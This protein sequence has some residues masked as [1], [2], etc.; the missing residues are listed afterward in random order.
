MIEGFEFYV[1]KAREHGKKIYFATILPFKGWRTY[2]EERNEIRKKLN[3]WI[4]STDLID[5][6]V[7]FDKVMQDENDPDKIPAHLTEEGLHPSVQGAKVLA[8]AFYDK[9]VK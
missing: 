4:R 3:E 7:D 6:Y 9:F 8:K 2:D 1:K 5:G